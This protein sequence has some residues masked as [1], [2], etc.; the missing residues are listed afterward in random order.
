MMSGMGRNPY[1]CASRPPTSNQPS[2]PRNFEAAFVP[3]GAFVPSGTLETFVCARTAG[4]HKVNRQVNVTNGHKA[5]AGAERD[6]LPVIPVPPGRDGQEPGILFPAVVTIP[7]LMASASECG[8]SSRVCMSSLYFFRSVFTDLDIRFTLYTVRPDCGEI[9][10]S[11]IQYRKYI[12][13]PHV[14]SYNLEAFT[15]KNTPAP[16]GTHSPSAVRGS[17]GPG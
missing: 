8:S 2:D 11:Q 3:A 16:A 12:R 17:R 9:R 6:R 15:N 10:Q 13:P 14:V 4:A 1:V 7:A 5:K